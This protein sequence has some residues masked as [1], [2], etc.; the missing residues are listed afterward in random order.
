MGGEAGES[1]IFLSKA[2]ESVKEVSCPGEITRHD[3]W[4]SGE[5]DNKER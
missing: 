1:R 3:C 2:G 5:Q 4:H